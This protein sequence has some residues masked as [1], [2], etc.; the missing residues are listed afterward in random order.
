MGLIAQGVTKF[1]LAV[2]V[3]ILAT[4]VGAIVCTLS[5]YVPILVARKIISE[6][7]T[8]GRTMF[9]IFFGMLLFAVIVAIA[10]VL[11][12]TNIL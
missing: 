2:L 11:F 12:G 4:L 5:F 1:N 9:G 7:N 10:S 3:A 8:V 6:N